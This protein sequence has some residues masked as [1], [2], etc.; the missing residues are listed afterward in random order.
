MPSLVFRK[1]LDMKA[2]VA[3][4]L[5]AAGLRVARFEAFSPASDP[6]DRTF[7]V[8]AATRRACGQ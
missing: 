6:G 1:G 5:A 3:D 4:E 2:A 7:L 8:E